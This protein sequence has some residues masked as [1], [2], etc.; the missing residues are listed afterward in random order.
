MLISRRAPDDS[1]DDDALWGDRPEGFLTN[2]ELV[3]SR[4]A[5][6]N[7]FRRC[8]LRHHDEGDDQLY[9]S[10]ALAVRRLK[11]RTDN[12]WDVWIW[13]ALAERLARKD[14]DVEWMLDHVEARCP[15]CSGVLKFEPTVRGLQ[16]KCAVNCRDQWNQDY[17]DPEIEEIVRTTYNTAF[18][19][20]AISK[21][22][23]L[24][25]LDLE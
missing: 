6:A 12:P 25:I 19:D 2:G 21:R 23:E 10:M 4:Y 15:R 20:D 11:T 8:H 24:A 14:Y 9:R 17:L 16:S 1:D 3:S 5:I 13:Y 18:P 22:Y 7:Y